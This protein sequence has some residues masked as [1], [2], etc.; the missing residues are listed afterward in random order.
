MT[1]RAAIVKHVVK[2]TKDHEGIREFSNVS[3]MAVRERISRTYLAGTCVAIRLNRLGKESL[4]VRLWQTGKT[5]GLWFA[6]GSV[7]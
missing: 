6:Q 5:R 2:G 1:V 4:G 3:Y 7:V